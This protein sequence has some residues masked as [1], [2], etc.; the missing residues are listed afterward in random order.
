M[1]ILR[2]EDA[3]AQDLGTLLGSLNFGVKNK[4]LIH[5][6]PQNQ[7]GKL[8]FAL[9]QTIIEPGKI[10]PKHYNQYKEAIY[11]I[12]GKGIIQIGTEE[13]AINTGDT[14]L[15]KRGETY[16][17]INSGKTELKTLSCVDLLSH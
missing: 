3:E 7:I 2:L 8:S 12:D 6:T 17:V 4:W 1:I 5:E 15:T 14:I 9:K 11:I 13:I 16:S 10:F